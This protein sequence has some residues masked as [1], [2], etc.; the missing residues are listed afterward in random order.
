MIN[1]SFKFKVLFELLAEFKVKGNKVL[2]FS[3]TKIFLDLFEKL[4]LQS[5]NHYSY[6]RLDGSVNI[7]N[8]QNMVE[9]FNKDPSIIC[10]LLTNAVSGVGLNLTGADRAV[11]VDPDWNPANDNQCIDRIYRIGQT[12]DVIV[13]RLIAANSVEE[14][15]YMRQVYKSSI[16]NAAIESK[17][18]TQ[19]TTKYFNEDELTTLVKFDPNKTGCEAFVRIRNGGSFTDNCLKDEENGTSDHYLAPLNIEKTAT[20][21]HH[22]EFLESLGIVGLTNHADLFANCEDNDEGLDD[23][24]D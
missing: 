11:I 13:Y 12:K 24:L 21:I 22:Q 16:N 4:L 17:S 2:I 6:Q 20:N 18:D 3:K 1:L 8:R 19:R 23:E 14:K 10:F 7:D 15:I 5:P 9:H